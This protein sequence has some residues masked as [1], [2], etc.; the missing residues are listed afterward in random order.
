M[1]GSKK[2]DSYI[3]ILL[4]SKPY[5]APTMN[6]VLYHKEISPCTISGGGGFLVVTGGGL[7]GG[8]VWV[9]CAEDAGF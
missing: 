9:L 4:K 5:I 3:I 6:I 7:S 8:L 2:T 1:A